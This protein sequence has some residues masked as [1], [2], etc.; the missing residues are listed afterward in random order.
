MQ[1]RPADLIGKIGLR[2]RTMR[3]LWLALMMSVVMYFGLTVFTGKP[4]AAT[5]NKVLSLA[6]LGV[7]MLTTL[8]SLL[9]KQ[10]ILSRAVAQRSEGMVQQAYVVAW[11]MCEASALLGL[12]DFY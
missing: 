12:V 3:T 1:Q 6:C 10:T 9:V 11:A 8:A 4:A 7:G 5:P 2:I